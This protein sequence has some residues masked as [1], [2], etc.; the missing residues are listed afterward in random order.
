MP[1]SHAKTSPRRRRQRPR[2]RVDHALAR[3]PHGARRKPG[4][5]GGGRPFC[6]DRFTAVAT[7]AK[8]E[9]RREIGRLEAWQRI[10]AKKQRNSNRNTN[11]RNR[12]PRARTPEVNINEVRQKASSGD[13][14]SLNE[15][16]ALLA[17]GGIASIG[18]NEPKASQQKQRQSKKRPSR[19]IDI[20]Q[21][22]TRGRKETRK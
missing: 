4:E 3:R 10:A 8:H 19:R 9:I 18:N 14:I 20:R 15:L 11:N 5:T 12:T 22:R 1:R 6:A 16:D 7:A 2:R 21:G 13:S 17:K